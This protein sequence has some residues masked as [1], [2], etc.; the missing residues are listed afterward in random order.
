[1]TQISA[2]L[3]I[4]WMSYTQ[5]SFTYDCGF[6]IR[7]TDTLHEGQIPLSGIPQQDWQ[8]HHVLLSSSVALSR[9]VLA[10]LSSPLITCNLSRIEAKHNDS[11]T[12]RYVLPTLHWVGIDIKVAFKS[13]A[14][15]STQQALISS[16]E[17]LAQGCIHPKTGVPYI[18]SFKAGRQNS[19]EEWTKGLELVFVLE[20]EVSLSFSPFSWVYPSDLWS[21]K[22]FVAEN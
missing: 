7:F 15:A 21:I 1:M 11:R 17:A 10:S 22:R 6:E 13:E 18:K 5:L 14:P 20:F 12:Y 19:P 9:T 3:F 4:A 16:F 2:R 8:A